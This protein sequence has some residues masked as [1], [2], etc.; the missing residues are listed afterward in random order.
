VINLEGGPGNDTYLVNFANNLLTSIYINDLG[1]SNSLVIGS[2][3]SFYFPTLSYGSLK[4][5]YE[6]SQAEIHLEN[7]DPNDVL[8][9]PRDIDTFVFSDIT[10]TYEELVALGF[11]LYGTSGDDVINGTSVVDRI[12]GLEGDDTLHGGTGDDVYIFRAGDGVDTIS[13]DVGENTIQLQDIGLD[14]ITTTSMTDSE[15][16]T[17]LVVNYGSSDAVYIENGLE[18]ADRFELVDG[19]YSTK[20]L[21]D[22]TF[23]DAN[24]APVVDMPLVD[25]VTAEDDLFTFQ[26][27]SGTF[28][29]HDA[30]DVLSL[31][32]DL[33]DGSAL[34]DWLSYDATTNTLSGTPGNSQ[35]GALDVRITATDSSGE[36]VSDI[37]TLDVTNINDAPELINALADAEA[38]EGDSFIYTVSADAFRDIDQGDS[39]T[40]TA[41]LSDG[42]SLPS[43]LRFDADA[44]TLSSE[45]PMD[46][47]GEYDITIQA[48]DQSGASVSDTFHLTVAN[49]VHEPTWWNWYRGTSFTDFIIGSESSEWMFG[50]GGNDQLLGNGGNDLLYGGTGNDYISGGNGRDILHGGQGDDQLQGGL[51]RDTLIGGRGSD[52]Y[53]FSKLDGQ[54][55]IR[56]YDA[57]PNNVDTLQFADLTHDELWFSRQRGDLVIDVIGTDDKV[58]I[59]NWYLSDDF[60]LDA[61]ETSDLVLQNDQVNQLVNA[62]AQFD[63]PSA[64]C[65]VYSREATDE[66][67]PVIAAS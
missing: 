24:H 25:Q 3:T 39:L 18:H 27:P 56:N 67:P 26:I 32:A 55:I 48:T 59:K 30:G 15:G 9:G 45:L 43:W 66:L 62:M 4:L 61:V 52:T 13:D 29:D 53:I 7:F 5:T 49:L 65:A 54:D 36:S 50:Y 34:P 6:N 19:V 16:S 2:P 58:T 12:T 38:V 41:R 51:G 21:V 40:Y 47:A 35:V 57:D 64:S 14:D 22:Y 33:S 20:E 60:Q 42:E 11:D 46:A 1:G 63:A 23:I 8:G 44:M 31:R 10:Y 37:F 17:Y 28:I